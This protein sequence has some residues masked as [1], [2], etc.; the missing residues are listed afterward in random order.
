[1]QLASTVPST[2][3]ESFGL[4]ADGGAEDRTPESDWLDGAGG[5]GTA[6]GEGSGGVVR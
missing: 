5:K 1:M 2:S 3:E 6:S 4:F